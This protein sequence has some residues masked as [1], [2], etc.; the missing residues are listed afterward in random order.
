MREICH[1]IR[2]TFKLK[3]C[4]FFQIIKWSKVSQ[5]VSNHNFFFWFS[6]PHFFCYTHLAHKEIIFQSG[7]SPDFHQFHRI[8][9]R[10]YKEGLCKFWIQSEHYLEKKT[11]CFTYGPTIYI[12]G[13]KSRK[14]SYIMKKLN[15]F[16]IIEIHIY[17]FLDT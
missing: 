3:I 11:S 5:K 7:R 12:Y 14:W 13:R 4:I 2:H 9:I 8:F 16:H 6:I 17:L 10:H 15:G 1:S